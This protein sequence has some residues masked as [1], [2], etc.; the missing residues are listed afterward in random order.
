MTKVLS[1]GTW[2]AWV[3]EAIVHISMKVLAV[4][5][6]NGGFGLLM[7]DILVLTMASRYHIVRIS[8]F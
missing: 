5:I 4:L 2:S 6:L 3:A 1:L 8:I 7:V